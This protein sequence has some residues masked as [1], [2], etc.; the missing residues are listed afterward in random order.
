VSR[1]RGVGPSDRRTLHRGGKVSELGI[2]GPC[3]TRP[4][5]AA[6]WR[7]ETAKRVAT[8]L[9]TQNLFFILPKI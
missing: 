5:P 4:H 9:R 1:W 8:Q 6:A 7:E 3:Q 2:S